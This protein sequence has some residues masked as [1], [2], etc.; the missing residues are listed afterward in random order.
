[1]SGRKQQSPPASRGDWLCRDEIRRERPWALTEH[2][3][4]TTR[5]SIEPDPP[6]LDRLERQVHD[7]ARRIAELEAKL[8]R[9][10][11]QEPDA[12]PEEPS[13]PL[14]TVA[15]RR[16]NGPDREFWLAHCEGFVVE[17]PNGSVGV[18]E[19][20]HFGSRLDLPDEVEIRAGR[21]RP[22]ELVVPIG[23]IEGIDPE[24]HR[25]RL[26]CDPR[27]ARRHDRSQALLPRARR[28][29]DSF[30]STTFR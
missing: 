17:S 10:L 1:M 19:A 8:Q 24:E 21:F 9:V 29:F 23:E 7:Q 30:V 22:F 13:A 25:I 26:T 14:R 4:E 6:T 12:S 28:R 2:L 5:E 20:V 27:V 18:V 11:A 16:R 3:F 15:L